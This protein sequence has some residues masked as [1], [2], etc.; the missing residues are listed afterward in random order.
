MRMMLRITVPTEE[1]NRG[2]KD[3]SLPKAIQE[4]IR[5]LKTEAAYFAA[6]QRCRSAMFFFDMQDTSEI[7]PIVEPWFLGFNAEVELLPVMNANDLKLGINTAV[8]AK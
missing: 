1:R 5:K 7:P 6:D 4:T 3:G 2:V 8:Q